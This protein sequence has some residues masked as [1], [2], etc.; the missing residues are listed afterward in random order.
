MCAPGGVLAGEA[1][2]ALAALLSEDASAEGR[3]RAL[4]LFEHAVASGEAV[5]FDVHDRVA[6][7][8]ASLDGPAS[9]P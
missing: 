9:T 5:P 4:W 1:S 8:R 2:V 3:E 6:S 7:L